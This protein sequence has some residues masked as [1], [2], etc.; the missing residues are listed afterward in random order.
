MGLKICN[1]FKTETI[2]R[3]TFPAR[4]K[5][6]SRLTTHIHISCDLVVKLLS[7]IILRNCDN[8]VSGLMLIIISLN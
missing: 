6:L 4:R 2:S 5:V 1:D 7:K 3:R 8:T